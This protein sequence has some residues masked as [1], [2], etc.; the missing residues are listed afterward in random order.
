MTFQNPCKYKLVKKIVN[1]GFNHWCTELI[2][3]NEW[4]VG[5]IPHGHC[6]A[7][8]ST[9]EK[10]SFEELKK[11]LIDQYNLKPDEI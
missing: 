8:L 1:P 3:G 2:A 5:F 6:H 9:K 4:G 10:Y 7:L 11:I